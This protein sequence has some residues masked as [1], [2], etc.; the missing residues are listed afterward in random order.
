MRQTEAQLMY[1]QFYCLF[2][3]GM[4]YAWTS[5]NKSL[6]L[7][8]EQWISFRR[9][10]KQDFKV[11]PRRRDKPV[12][13]ERMKYSQEDGFM[14]LSAV[15]DS[16]NPPSPPQCVLFSLTML[17]LIYRCISLRSYPPSIHSSSSHF[18]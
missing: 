8:S 5:N 1:R 3:S 16:T 7:S 15:Y 11:E 10:K 13:E 17:I 2:T 9:A 4:I 18:P 6:P 12:D 14:S